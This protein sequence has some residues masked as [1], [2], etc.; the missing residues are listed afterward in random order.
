MSTASGTPE[1]HPFTVTGAGIA[2]AVRLT[3]NA[4]R[5]AIEATTK[6]SDG[7]TVLV[8]RVRAQPEKGK[9]NTALIKLVAKW[10]GVPRSTVELR[11]GATSRLK[12]VLVRGGGRAL[13]AAALEKLAECRARMR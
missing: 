6:L 8:A 5:D 12:T 3:P 7:R 10:L 4:A 2:V 11:S 9:A 1:K 13:Q